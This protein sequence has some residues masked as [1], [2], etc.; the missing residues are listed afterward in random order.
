MFNNILVVCVGNICRSPMAEALLRD[1]LSAAGKTGYSVSSAGLG[2]LVDH[3]PDKTACE[4]LLKK[5]I[6]ISDYKATQINSQLVRK[7]DLILVMETGHKNALV[8]DEPSAKGKVFRLGEWGEFDIPD[9]Y[10]KDVAAFE[11]ALQLV[12]KGIAQWLKK[13]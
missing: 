3:A 12:E 11:H 1:A 10:Q 13:I 8:G 4:L 6:D 5:G 9:P 7:A 2:A